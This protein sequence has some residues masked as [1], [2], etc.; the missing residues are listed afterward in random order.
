MKTLLH[1]LWFDDR[2]AVVSAEI[3][4]VASILVIGVI[5]GLAALRDSIV[6]ELADLAQAIA[7]A[8][9]SYSFSGVSG[10]HAFSGGGAFHDEADFCDRPWQGDWGNSKCIRIC[11]AGGPVGECDGPGGDKGGDW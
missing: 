7:N 4:L 3:M 1:R 11:S 10:H 9:Q 8:N 5:T 6:T 2:G